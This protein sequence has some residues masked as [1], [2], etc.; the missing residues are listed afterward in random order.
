M[1]HLLARPAAFRRRQPSRLVA[2]QVV[3]LRL[4]PA[5][6]TERA[7]DQSNEIS[8]HVWLGMK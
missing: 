6:Q 5:N 1:K 4:P 3:L 7:T 8:P 2:S